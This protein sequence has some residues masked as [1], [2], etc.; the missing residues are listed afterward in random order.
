MLRS[1]SCLVVLLAPLAAQ[2]PVAR[3]PREP[4]LRVECD[5]AAA[6]RTKFAGTNVALAFGDREL[7]DVLQPLWAQLDTLL[8]EG[9][10]QTG[11]DVPGIWQKLVAYSGRLVMTMELGAITEDEDPKMSFIVVATPDGTTDVSKLA[12]QL[13]ALLEEMAGGQAQD[14]EVAGRRLR[15]TDDG[16]VTVALPFEMDGHLVMLFGND[17]EASAKR[18]LTAAPEAVDDF[19]PTRAGGN[20]VLTMRLATQQLVEKFF[21]YLAQQPFLADGIKVLE[22]LGAKQC[23]DVTVAFGPDNADTILDAAIE[24]QGQ[25]PRLLALLQPSEDATLHGG[26]DLVPIGNDGWG[27]HVVR[28]GRLYDLIL[29]IIALSGEENG[30]TT[31]VAMEMFEQQTGVRLKED[32]FDHLGNHFVYTVLGGA[33]AADLEEDMISQY[34]PF[35]AI[36]VT[37]RNGEALGASIEK[38]L[39]NAGMHAAR[40]SEEY[41]GIKVY[42]MPVMGMFKIEY[43]TTDRL[44]A[45]GIGAGGGKAI[46][47]LLAEDRARQAGQPQ[48]ELDRGVQRLLTDLG[49]TPSGLAVESIANMFDTIRDAAESEMDADVEEFMDTAG[50][51]MA[52]LS[53]AMKRANISRY[54]SITSWQQGR[55]VSRAVW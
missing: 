23:G 34:L 27:A 50:P 37:V 51:V 43:A 52:A 10:Q 17:V 8:A 35:H 36:G 13:Q 26:L 39:R 12:E 25:P 31:D 32:L 45:L 19:G 4:L 22:A 38:M 14:L 7:Q 41:Q 42:E 33:D 40:K 20:H 44:A 24:F 1:V 5:G 53:R 21:E 55:F 16:E 47:Q 9:K 49:G 30:M 28:F 11:Q 48:G 29:H 2:D 46:R 15:I 3:L 18:F 54:V 6:W